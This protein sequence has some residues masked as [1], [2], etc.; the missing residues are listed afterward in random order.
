MI[1]TK[2]KIQILQIRCFHTF[3]IVINIKEIKNTLR[4]FQAENGLKFKNTQAEIKRVVSYKKKS[5][6]VFC[7]LAFN[8]ILSLGSSH[9][10]RL[11]VCP[12]ED[13]SYS[14]RSSGPSVWTKHSKTTVDNGY[15]ILDM[16]IFTQ[17]TIHKGCLVCS[18]LV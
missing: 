4:E 6:L 9:S 1:I 12:L 17:V 14:H 3:H 16:D 10:A 8:Q 2:F 7:G 11:L 13:L 18:V 15:Q 5:V